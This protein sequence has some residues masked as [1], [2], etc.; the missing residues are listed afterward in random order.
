MI[1]CEHCGK[2][3]TKKRFCSRECMYAAKRKPR[4]KCPNCGKDAPRAEMQFC[5]MKCRDEY[6]KKVNEKNR[7]YNKCIICG[8]ETLN[9][10]YCSMKCM[11]EDRATMTYMVDNLKNENSW[12]EEKLEYLKEN[13]GYLPLEEIADHFNSS[14]SAIIAT[15]NRYNIISVRKWTDEEIEITRNNINNIDYLLKELKK[16]PSAIAN[17][18]KRIALENTENGY[19]TSPE[20]ICK[21][22]LDDLELQYQREVPVDNFRLDFLIDKLD[23]EVQG[24]YYHCDTRFYPNGAT[25][26]MQAYMISKDKRRT[27]YLESKGYEVL[28]IWEHD[29]YVNRDYVK[30]LIGKAVLKSRN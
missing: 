19:N 21:N 27:D 9:E 4:S 14:T 11:G 10:K 30:E 18:I 8:K 2:E 15:A 7:Q 12:T 3:T 17:Q 28:Y 20:T 5:S 25:N 22:I 6:K 23:I 29:L 24:T 26:D 1:N 16:S 13:Y